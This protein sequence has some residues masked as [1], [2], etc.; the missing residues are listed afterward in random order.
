MML[1]VERQ[2]L[3]ALIGGREDLDDE[4]GRVQPDAGCAGAVQASIGHT[5]VV[6]GLPEVEL[7]HPGQQAGAAGWGIEQHREL[8]ADE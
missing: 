8:L 5:E 4:R 3:P 2:L 6:L 7:A 1:C